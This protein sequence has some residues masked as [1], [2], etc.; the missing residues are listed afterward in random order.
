V[1]YH[2]DFRSVDVYLLGCAFC[3]LLTC[4]EAKPPFA[5]RG[6]EE[7]VTRVK[8]SVTAAVASLPSSAHVAM[9]RLL[10]QMTVDTLQVRSPPTLDV[11]VE[12]LWSIA[13]A[14]PPVATVAVGERPAGVA[15]A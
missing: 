4:G 15:I 9:R 11:V 14:L 8:E 3:E 13:T 5:E 2:L 12:T 10:E 7:M 1:P 6:P